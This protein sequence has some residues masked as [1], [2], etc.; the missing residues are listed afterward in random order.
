MI[1]TEVLFKTC[2]R[3]LGGMIVNCILDNGTTVVKKNRLEI[4]ITNSL[5]YLVEHL[6]ITE[7]FGSFGLPG[8][9]N[10]TPSQNERK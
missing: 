6:K 8:V 9:T 5:D 2:L 1:L 4:I 10:R 7:S 3:F